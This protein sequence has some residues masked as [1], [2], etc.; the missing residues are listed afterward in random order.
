MRNGCDTTTR[1]AP[2]A[3][4]AKLYAT[5]IEP[6][7]SRMLNG[8]DTTTPQARSV[9]CGTRKVHV[10]SVWRAQNPPGLPHKPGIYKRTSIPSTKGPAFKTNAHSDKRRRGS[11]CLQC[12]PP[13]GAPATTRNRQTEVIR[14]ARLRC[15]PG[16]TAWMA[17]WLRRWTRNLWP[18]TPLGSNPSGAPFFAHGHV[19][20]PQIHPAFPRKP[21]M[22]KWTGIPS[23]KGPA[24]KTNQTHTNPAH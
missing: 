9:V 2:T 22:Y 3:L 4:S 8:C 19:P 1:H 18:H 14:Q 12:S 15:P 13:V 16:P 24:F 5:G 17:D 10:R 23:T 21:G 11:T 7:A 20:M 6:G